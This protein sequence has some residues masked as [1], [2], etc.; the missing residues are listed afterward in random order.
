MKWYYKLLTL[1]GIGGV[2]IGG[3]WLLAVLLLASAQKPLTGESVPTAPAKEVKKAPVKRVA[4][5][6]GVQ[7]YAG[8]TKANLKLPAAVIEDNRQEVVAATQVKASDRPQTV[9]TTVDTEKGTFQ[10]F[11]RQ[12]PYPWFAVETRGEAR[13]SIGYRIDGLEPPKP[14]VRLG[15]NYDVIRVKAITAGITTTIDSDGRAFAGVGV[16]YRW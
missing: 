7:V 5:K 9:T 2:A 15:I 4:P 10:T 11:V 1:V 8:G 14:I 3:A 16:A 6:G 12:D 13:L